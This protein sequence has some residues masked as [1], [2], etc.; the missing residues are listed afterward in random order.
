MVKKKSFTGYWSS[1]ES[2]LRSPPRP[3]SCSSPTSQL[4]CD[5]EFR[6]RCHGALWDHRLMTEVLTIIR[7]KLTLTLRHF[8]ALLRPSEMHCCLTFR[9]VA[10]TIWN[11]LLLDI[12]LRC[13]DHLECTAAWHFA[14][15]LRPSGMHC[16]L[17][18]RCVAPTIWNA[19]LL[20]ISLRCSDHLEC[21]AAWHSRLAI[22]LGVQEQ[23]E[24]TLL[25]TRF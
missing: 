23:T 14:A 15:L 11:A 17:T 4:I 16:H 22:S 7:L 24:S 12:S 19:M 2:I 3:T 20:D 18:F 13:S 10:P 25:S 1:G 6:S 8:A 5:R 9:C 21:T